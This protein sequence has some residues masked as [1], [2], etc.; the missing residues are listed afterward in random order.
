ML[1]CVGATP[2]DLFIYLILIA[3]YPTMVIKDHINYPLIYIKSKYFYFIPHAAFA[4]HK[5][6][7][8]IST[9]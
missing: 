8:S 3:H 6:I 2:T 9:T 4:M 5:E 1:C 7:D